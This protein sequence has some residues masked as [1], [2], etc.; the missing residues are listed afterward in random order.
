M[1]RPSFPNTAPPLGEIVEAST[2]QFVAQCPPA[3]LYHPPL[4]GSIVKT[5]PSSVS[6]A[7]VE[8]TDFDPF[9]LPVRS[10]IT[11]D[12]LVEG[13]VY[14]VVWQASTTS[15][16]PSR[17]PMAYG[18]SESQLREEQPQIF[19]LLQTEFSALPIATVEQGRLRMTLPSRPPRLHAFVGACTAEEVCTLTDTPDLLR[20]ILTAPAEVPMDALLIACI[21]QAWQAR[22]QDFSYL[23]QAGKRLAQ[24]LHNEPDRL[25]A[26]LRQLE[27]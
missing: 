18:M 1:Q 19:E 15:L 20:A 10:S 2:T 14:A 11:L 13:T 23:V 8:E 21:R 9:E 7:T 6:T 26:I 3:N 24:L 5:P 25:T 17:R 16:D 12:T 27:P 4:F 22:E